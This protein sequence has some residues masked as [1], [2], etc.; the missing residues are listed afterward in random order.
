MRVLCPLTVLQAA[1]SA[2]HTPSEGP[3]E[4]SFSPLLA[5]AGRR[6]AGGLWLVAASLQPLRLPSRGIPDPRLR[7]F[8][9]REDASHWIKA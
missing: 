7:L 6:P 1:V 2:G 9:S 8:L 3:W 5:S 4:G